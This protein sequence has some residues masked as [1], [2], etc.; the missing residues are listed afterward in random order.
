MSRKLLVHI[1][2]HC[3]ST[4][5]SVGLRCRG[6]GDLPPWDFRVPGGVTS[7]S[8]DFHKYGYSPKGVS[9]LL[10]R[11]RDL[12]RKQYFGL[13]DWPG[14]YPVVNPTL[15]GSKS[16]AA[17][18]GAWAIS[19]VLGQSG[20][21]ELVSRAQ[22]ATRAL[23]GTVEAIEGLRVVGSPVGPLF[24]VATD[25]SVPLERRVDP[26][27][28]VSAVGARG[29]V[30]QGSRRRRNLTGRRC[31]NNP[32]HRHPPV[33]ESVL[34][35]LTSALVLGADDVRGSAA[36]EA[37]PALAELAGAFERGDVTVADVLALPSD[38]VAAALTS[39]GGLDPRGGSSDSPLDMAAVLAAVES[40]PR[41]VTKRLLVEFLAGMVEPELGDEYRNR[42]EHCPK[43][44]Q[45]ARKIRESGVSFLSSANHLL[46]EG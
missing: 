26:H 5:A 14:G 37:P 2:F 39:A 42:D 40:L 45:M 30:L 25:D 43:L 46:S 34:G 9:V 36:A 8:V 10:H 7:M 16:V 4:P 38:A 29:F 20:Y 6:G 13:T 18:A 24:A 12:H 15:L 44:G 41:E 19:Q 32:P 35:E 23:I 21:A 1:R 22:R 3:M 28:W 11:G 27:R 31:S 33:T 17:L